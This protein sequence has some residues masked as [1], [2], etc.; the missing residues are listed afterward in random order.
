[1]TCEI[2]AQHM[3][4]SVIDDDTDIAHREILEIAE[5]CIVMDTSERIRLNVSN[6]CLCVLLAWIKMIVGQAEYKMSTTIMQRFELSG[7]NCNATFS[8]LIKSIK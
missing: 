1:M 4:S 2:N 7:Q 5:R 6:V 3:L 8:I